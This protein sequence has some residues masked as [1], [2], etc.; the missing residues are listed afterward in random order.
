VSRAIEAGKAATP[1]QPQTIKL[2]GLAPGAT[3]A[4]DAE[5]KSIR[6][7]DSAS[8]TLTV[9]GT[10]DA[11]AQRKLLAAGTPPSF[12]HAIEALHEK[13]QDARVS[14][15]WLFLFYFITTIGELCLSPVGLAMVTKL[16]PVRFASLFMGVWLLSS[17]VAQ[18]VGGTLGESWG[19]VT[20]VSYFTIFAATSAVGAVVL[21]VLVKPLKRLMH[22]VS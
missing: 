2:S 7:F 3:I 14:G 10:L 16:A 5:T 8:G 9:T 11:S 15:F 6:G 12:R 18:Y 19:I 4:I 21:L 17:S 22:G 13:S 1:E 20:P